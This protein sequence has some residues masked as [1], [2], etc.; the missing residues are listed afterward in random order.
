MAITF[1]YGSNHVQ[2]EVP[3]AKLHCERLGIKHIVIPL[4]FIHQYSFDGVLNEH[5]TAGR[6]FGLRRNDF[7]TEERRPSMAADAFPDEGKK[8]CNEKKVF[9]DERN[10]RVVRAEAFRMGRKLL[11]RVEKWGRVVAEMVQA[12]SDKASG[13]PKVALRNVWRFERVWKALDVR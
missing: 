11:R 7:R 6:G 2:K 13:R 4:D 1:D 8:H 12:F 3:F 5:V 9:P 10:K